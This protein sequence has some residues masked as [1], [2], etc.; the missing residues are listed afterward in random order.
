MSNVTTAKRV[1]KP[2]PKPA[3]SIRLCV[4]PEG[5]TPGVLRI[6]V[7]KEQADYFLTAVPADFGRAFRLEKIGE[8]DGEAYHVNLDGQQRTCEC[9][10]HLRHNHCKHADGLAALIAAGRL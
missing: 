7:G 3:R 9:K 6:T 1:R 2:R 8:E 4:N 5:Q 10:G